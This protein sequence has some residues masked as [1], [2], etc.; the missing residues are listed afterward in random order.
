MLE[1][2]FSFANMEAFPYVPVLICHILLPSHEK[3]QTA[4]MQSLLSDQP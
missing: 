4:Q 3:D 2:A 1:N